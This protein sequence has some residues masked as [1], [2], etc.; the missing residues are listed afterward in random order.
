MNTRNKIYIAVTIAAV[1][2]VG[3]FG[4]SVWS[5]HKVSQ[6]ERRIVEARQTAD[7]TQKISEKRDIDAA[8]YLEKIAYLERRIA[9][10]QTQARKQDEQ[11]EKHSTN[12]RN[13][14][15]DLERVR[16]V[17]A[18]DASIPGLCEKLAAL[19]HQCA[20]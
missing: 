4:G 6:L 2:A 5:D 9:E 20:E 12:T 3:I 13:A 19:G 1:L 17:R 10:N 11:I 7:E 14:R 15:A 8:A 18:N 16:R